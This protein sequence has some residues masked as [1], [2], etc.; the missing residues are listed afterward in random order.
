MASYQPPVE[1]LNQFNS[2]VF[3]TANASSI[4]LSKAQSS[5]LGR[6]GNPVSI[7]Q[8]TTFTG[9]VIGI[10]K[11]MVGL[12][13]CDNTSD[14]NKPISTATGAAL[15]LCAT[16]A[17]NNIFTGTNTFNTSLPTST[18]TPSSSTQ[19]ITKAYG[20]STYT[21]SGSIL[22]GANV[23]TGTNTFNTS[24][25]TSTIAPTTQYQ[26]VN[27]AYADLC[28]TLAGNNIFTGTNTF[29]TSLPTS[30]LTPSSSTQLITKAYGDS[31]YT[32]SG[33]MLS[34]A[35]AWTGN[36]NT[37]NSFLPTSTIAPT[38][39]Y[40]FVNKAYVD[41]CAT[42]AGNNAFAGTNTFNTSLPTSTQTPTTSTQ[43]IT[44]AYGDSTYTTSGAMLSAAN[45]WTGNTN[46]FNSFLPTSTIAPTTQ[47][48]FTNKAY[49]DLCAKLAG[50][51][52]FTGTTNTFTGVVNI[53]GVSSAGGLIINGLL[54]NS[55]GVLQLNDANSATS[56][57]LGYIYNSSGINLYRSI[58]NVGTTTSHYFATI[59]TAGVESYTMTIQNN[60]ISLL[61]PTTITGLITGSAGLTIS[62]GTSA[63]QATTTTTLNSSGL[64]TGTNG[65]TISSGTSAL[66]AT[67]TT[68]LNSSGL[69]TGTNGLTISSGT[70][71]ATNYASSTGF[72]FKDNSSPQG[73]SGFT[74]K[75]ST[76]RE[77]FFLVENGSS[78]LTT[79]EFSFNSRTR[80][81]SYNYSAYPTLT[82]NKE[83]F[84]IDCDNGTGTTD[85]IYSY[86]PFN[87]SELIT[88]TNGLTISTGTSALQATTT[89]TLNSSGLITG[90]SGLTISSGTT[91]LQATTTTSLSVSNSLT[92]S[93]ATFSNN[94][95]YGLNKVYFDNSYGGGDKIVLYDGGTSA[96]NYSFGVNADTLYYNSPIYH[97]FY[98]NGTTGTPVLQLS[99]TLTTINKPT[100]ITGLITGSNG[101]TIST[102]TSA[103]KATTTT[104]LNSSGL[105]TGSSGL[106]ITSGS[107]SLQST[108]TT[109]LNTSGLITGTSG[110]TISA[111]STSLQSTAT[112]T[113]NSSGLIT[114]TAGL[115]ISAGSTSLQS[116]ATTTLNASGL[117]TA[118]AGL[119]ITSG[120]FNTS[121]PVNA[122]SLSG[123]ILNLNDY[124]TNT[125]YYG[126]IYQ[127]N[128]YMTIRS[129]NNGTPVSD[130]APQEP[131]VIFLQTMNPSNTAVN[132]LTLTPTEIQIPVPISANYSSLASVN[133]S[134]LGGQKIGTYL[135]PTFTSG[136]T[137]AMLSI[138]L[139]IGVWNIC[140]RIEVYSSATISQYIAGISIYQNS[141]IN[142]IV[143]NGLYGL[144][145]TILQTSLNTIVRVSS[146]TT[147]YLNLFVVYTGTLTISNTLTDS[148]TATRIA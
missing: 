139:P 35:N 130:P 122:N 28:A 83:V 15:S 75:D 117:I 116:T 5:F 148:L 104:T 78:N 16:L 145:S 136:A 51:N 18:L 89:T 3:K 2:E 109:A 20:D 23:W 33:A 59:N 70:V 105:I 42:L 43:L 47:Y 68:T 146:A 127:Q 123:K 76:G 9:T 36:T 142:Q 111:G 22:S 41:L 40:Q 100:T 101:L 62:T 71:T 14:V 54:S 98:V 95:M 61:K 57:F 24:L 82:L 53:T 12:G 29:N 31:T 7:A 65:L 126:N 140:G 131:T 60:A 113:L 147:Y 58:G 143:S 110:L 52:I 138:T 141:P 86:V 81:Y 66:Q 91:A 19:L 90:T 103:L 39:Q 96:L 133:S 45:A 67:T 8:S 84:K 79:Q 25:P 77:F 50:N 32:T 88:G 125:S 128:Q 6:V 99:S 38:T 85:A 118:S 64:I 63:L 13:N 94:Q 48:Q 1:A 108:A 26:F 34:A 119:T 87:S 72:V 21:T 97:N 93:S 30:T 69:I 132:T 27:K 46:T 74:V 124:G 37:F 102:G 121:G 4:S 44:K 11:S 49:V 17:G 137:K 135:A 106:T 73:S 112:T 10:T 144:S 56:G 80:F 134:Y 55:A 107:T 114:G 129:W 120:D 92:F 115:T